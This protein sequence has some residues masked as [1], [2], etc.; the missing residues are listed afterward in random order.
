[1]KKKIKNVSLQ[2]FALLVD[3]KGKV[4]TVWV[5]PGQVIELDESSITNQI[6]TLIRRRNVKIY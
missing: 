3:E 1:M 2:T 4:T 6:R 5:K